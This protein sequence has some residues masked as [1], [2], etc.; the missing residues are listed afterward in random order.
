MEIFRNGWQNIDLVI[1]DLILPYMNGRELYYKFKAIDPQVKVL[2]SSGFSQAGQAEELLGEG[3]LGFVQKPYD[4]AEL[5][6]M[7]IEILST[8]Q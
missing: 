6:S 3:C 7:M 4:I 1:L 8:P 5:S 2:L